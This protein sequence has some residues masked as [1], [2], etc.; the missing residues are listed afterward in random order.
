M[1][2]LELVVV[3]ALLGLV[4]GVAAPS[5]ILP[6]RKQETALGGVIATARRAAVLRGEPV[7][8][9]VETEGRWRIEGSARSS[10]EPIATGTLAQ[11]VGS[12]RVHLTPLGAC[13][14]EPFADE[15]LPA[16]D[17]V[18][19]TPARAADDAGGRP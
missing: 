15:A 16:W 5:F 9:S 10:R 6:E 12:L 3:L 8:L 14:L 18:N 2:L 19:C 1:T 17:A 4:L 7:T 13:V 11:H